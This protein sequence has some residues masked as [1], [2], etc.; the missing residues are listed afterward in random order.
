MGE[1]WSICAGPQQTAYRGI[2][3]RRGQTR[4]VIRF[5][6]FF[7]CS[8]ETFVGGVWWGLWPGRVEGRGL[9]GGGGGIFV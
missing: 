4:W 1:F 5:R 8:V 7:S 9:G 3:A 6:P 2:A